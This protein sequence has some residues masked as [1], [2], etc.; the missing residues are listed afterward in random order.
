MEIKKFVSVNKV[1]QQ[2]SFRYRKYNIHET[3]ATAV[4][5]FDAVMFTKKRKELNFFICF[6]FHLETCE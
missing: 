2:K 5:Y 3:M 1:F 6:S 4:V